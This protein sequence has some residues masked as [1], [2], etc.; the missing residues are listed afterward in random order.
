MKMNDRFDE[1][2]GANFNG[3]I[4]MGLVIWFSEYLFEMD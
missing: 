1:F 3:F 4:Q 2:A